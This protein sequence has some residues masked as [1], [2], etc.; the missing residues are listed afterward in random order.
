MNADLEALLKAFEAH[1]EDP[2]DQTRLVMYLSRLE[3]TSEKYSLSVDTLRDA[4]RK[5]YPKW[6]RANSKRTGIPPKA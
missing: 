4:I 5:K 3:D 6:E 2:R 1:L